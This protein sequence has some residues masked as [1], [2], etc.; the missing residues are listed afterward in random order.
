MSRLHQTIQAKLE[1]RQQLEK[2]GIDTDPVGFEKT[3]TVAECVSRLQQTVQTAGRIRSIRTHGK[4][5]FIDVEDQSGKIQ[6]MIRFQEVG[7]TLFALLPFIDTGDFIGVSGQVVTTDTGEVT[8]QATTFQFLGKSLRPLPTAWNAAED[9]EVRFRK[10]YLDMLVS[11]DTRRILNARWT[12]LKELRRYLQD[13]QNFTEVETPIL[14]PLYGGTNAKPFSTHMNALDTDFYLRLAPELYLKRLIVGGY[15]RVFEIARNFRNEGIDQTHQPE[16]TMVEWYEA[17]ADYHRMMDVTEGLFKHLAQKLYGNLQLQVVEHQIDLGGK[18]PRMTMKAA[19]QQFAD[20]AFDA[21]DDEQVQALYGKHNIQKAGV[22]SRGK[23]LFELFDK[24]VTPQL[25]QPTWIIDYPKEVSPLSKQHRN[26]ANLVER[27]EGYI[28]GK[29]IADGWSEITDAIDQRSRFENE[30]RNM[31]AG[32]DE[33][34]PVDED[35]LEAM[36]YGMPPLGGIGIGI[37]RLTMFLTNTWSIKE[38]IA[39]PTLRPERRGPA[40]KFEVLDRPDLLSISDSI[41]QAYPSVTL[42]FAILKGVHIVKSLPELEAEKAAVLDSLNGLTTEDLGKFPEILSYRQMY[43]AMGVDWHSRRPSPEALLRRIAQGKGLY[44]I[45][46]CVDAY[47]LVVMKH[48]VSV[49]AFDLSQV[50]FPTVLDIAKGGEQILLLGD[51][52]PTTLKAGE[53]SYFDTDGPYNLDY[54]YRDAQRTCV[55]EHTTDLLINVDGVYDIS[56]QQIEESLAETIAIIQKY[57]GGQ[58]E[59]AGIIQ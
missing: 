23:A 41:T 44:T 57:C 17:Y 49:G 26:D 52:E 15:D 46:T 32:D 18:W 56:R 36:E 14:Q 11:Q 43:K 22:Y 29:E 38:V 51:S 6:V 5:S 50:K 10:R 30:Q 58:V 59:I 27:F 19:L 48:R 35:F 54:N 2:L 1:K 3:L 4:V 12:I 40:M 28:G 37:D 34:H 47:N 31:R 8:I 21:L 7:E 33:A 25:I 45:N 55:Q 9:K 39:F 20:V 16:F 13:E 53:V 42:G 24:L